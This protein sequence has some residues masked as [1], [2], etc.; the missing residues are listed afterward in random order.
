MLRRSI[1]M[2]A[3]TG[4]LVSLAFVFPVSANT[5]TV[6]PQP[7]ASYTSTTNLINIS[8]LSGNVTSIT[9]GAL[10]V[11]FSTSMAVLKTGVTNGWG[12][13]NSPPATEGNKPTVLYTKGS[14]DV[15]MTLSSPVSLFGFEAQPDLSDTE[16]MKASYYDAG[17]VLLGT[18]TLNVSG[19]AGALLF[20]VSTGV[21]DIAKIDVA[22]SGSGG[23]GCA[24]CDFA[25]AQVRFSQTPEP[26]TFYL[27]GLGL[28]L[29]RR[30]AA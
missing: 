24:G 22:D 16:T 5:L 11:N 15:V 8:A 29:L 21:N 13:W 7:V 14:N 2:P 17:N 20:A 27:A 25:L 4:V 10:T 19:N 28:L 18:L 30:F 23:T 6:I 12:V 9:G 26:V 1:L 3:V